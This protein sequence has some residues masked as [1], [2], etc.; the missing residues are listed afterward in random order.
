MK[1]FIRISYDGSKFY[2]F[3][4]LNDHCTVQRTLEEALS[5]IDQ[6]EVEVKGAGRT[7]RGVHANDQGVHFELIHDIPT[8]G[9][10]SILNKLV[11]PYIHIKS[12]EV[13]DEDFHARFSVK[14]KVYR[15]RMYFGEYNPQIFDY[16][17]ECMEKPDIT[18][19][20]EASKF[21]LGVHDF[22]N[23]VSGERDDYTSVVYDISFVQDGDFLDII[24]VGK[25]F[26]RYMVRNM[27][28]ALLDVGFKKREKEEIMLALERGHVVKQFTTA[29]SNG[30][31]LDKIE[32]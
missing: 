14:Q 27:V 19:M 15:Y 3:Q 24:F 11:G 12:C 9:L 25:S 7:D 23:F 5:Q 29:V 26:Y 28:G 20:E 22:H 13:V 32:Y 16:V 2:G 21:F 4:R 8:D 1:Y 31:Y 30:L 10:V 18:R 6:N 17:Y